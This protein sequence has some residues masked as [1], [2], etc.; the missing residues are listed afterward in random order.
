[1]DIFFMI[2]TTLLLP[3]VTISWSIIPSIIG[4]A[5]GIR[6]YRITDNSQI[7][8]IMN[9]LPKRSSIIEASKLRGWVWGY[10]Y[11]GYIH[12]SMGFGR[13]GGLSVEIYIFTTEKF[14]TSITLRE[15][16]VLEN[17]E[18]IDYYERTGNYYS[19]TYKKRPY[20]VKNIE[21]RPNQTSAIGDIKKIYENKKHAVVFLYGKPNT[22]KSTIPIL[23]SKELKGSICTTFNPTEPGDE[24]IVLYNTVCP[25]KESPLVVVF[26]EVDG[27]INKIKKNNITEHKNIPILVK[28]KCSWNMFFDNIDRGMYPNLIII[29]TSNKSPYS[30]DTDIYN[31]TSYLRE[32]RVDAKIEISF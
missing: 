10:P 5:F 9:K 7:Q 2:L 27:V 17:D 3:L 1:M 32:G 15:E 23:L 11:I 16:N 26:E 18:T 31:D 20:S 6:I 12:E 21:P 22:G 19:L 29:M 13:N 8:L 28:D 30:I 25:S 14:Y 24:L 4:W